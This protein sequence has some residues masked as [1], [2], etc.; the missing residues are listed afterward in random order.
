MGG[1][2]VRPTR[3]ERGWRARDGRPA[4]RKTPRA[5][6][7]RVGNC[8]PGR[9][10]TSPNVPG[11]AGALR[12]ARARLARRRREAWE[13]AARPRGGGGRPPVR[14]R[15][16]AAAPAVGEGSSGRFGRLLEKAPRAGRARLY[17]RAARG[18]CASCLCVPVLRRCGSRASPSAKVRGGG[19]RGTWGSRDGWAA[20]RAAPGAP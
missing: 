12:R 2:S 17:I 3:A 5:G 15:R 9:R 13:P 20:A 19:C 14:R 6:A 8:G 10:E 11:R 4:R 18:R 7:G 16:R 1:E